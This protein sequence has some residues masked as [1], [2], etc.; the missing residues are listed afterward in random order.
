MEDQIELLF[1]ISQPSDIQQ[2]NSHLPTS[3]TMDPGNGTDPDFW[4][5][6]G[7]KCYNSHYG[8]RYSQTDVGG[9]SP[10]VR[11]PT[12]LQLVNILRLTVDCPDPE[13]RGEAAKVLQ[14]VQVGTL[15]YPSESPQVLWSLAADVRD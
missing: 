6:V 14:E 1:R 12:V 8:N 7:L 3:T 11:S 2:S 10:P 5:E 9:Q 15:I 4:E 13:V